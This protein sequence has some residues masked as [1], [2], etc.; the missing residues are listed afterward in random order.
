MIQVELR[1][2][3]TDAMIATVRMTS[4]PQA[5]DTLWLEPKRDEGAFKVDSVAHWVSDKIEYHKVCVYVYAV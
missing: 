1:D 5:G 2:T 4:P 3:E